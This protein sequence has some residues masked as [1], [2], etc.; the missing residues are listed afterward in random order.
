M[1]T[2]TNS[3]EP[4]GMVHKAAFPQGVGCLLTNNLQ[5][6]IYSKT[7]VRQSLKNRQNKDLNHKW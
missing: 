7:C 3:E 1:G 2:L 4:D 6:Q 5:E